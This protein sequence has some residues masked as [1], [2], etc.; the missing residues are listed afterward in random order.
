MGDSSKISNGVEAALAL[1]DGTVF[2]GRAIGAA[3]EAYGEVVFNT[4]MS[5]YQ[6][7][8]TDP[9]YKG[10]IVTMTYPQIGNY[11]VNKEDVESK[12][13]FLEGFIVRELSKVPSNWRMEGS[14]EEYLKSHEIVAIDGVD[15][16]ELTKRL[17]IKG[18][19]KGLI[20]TIDL[21]EGGLIKKVK[22]S[23]GLVGMD[24][25]KEVTC[26]QAY[27]FD[28]SFPHPPHFVVTMDFGVKMNILRLLA[29]SGCRVKVVPADT[30][31]DEIL[32]LS[33]DGIVLSNGPGDPEAVGYAISAIKD[34][35]NAQRTTHNGLPIFGIC[36][37][38]QLLGIALG[39][40]TYKL[41]FGHHG[42]NHPVM[43][44]STK[45]V[46]ITSQNHGFAVDIDSIPDRDVELT[47]INLND[48]TVEGMR[49][50]VLPIFSVQ[51][52][53]E[54]SP[55][56]HDSRYLFDRFVKMMQEHGKVNKVSYNA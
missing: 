52:H 56:P 25:A 21:D 43:E 40:K 17:R 7:I 26:K 54:A 9:S 13:P 19:M 12:T 48:N 11:G 37:G 1:D 27:D 55:G 34:L 30:T 14:L 22:D 15:T 47:H 36:L 31:A 32:K 46:G 50:K 51:Y 28:C 4:A 23:P 20:S 5:G 2:K 35:I 8:L 10:Q 45:K 18:A 16:R 44:V 38:H 49:H 42:A 33:P 41:K 53:P 3:G 29:S 39:G 6:E 24:L